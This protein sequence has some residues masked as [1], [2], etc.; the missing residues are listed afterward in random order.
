MRKRTCHRQATLIF[1]TRRPAL[2]R[3]SPARVLTD[4]LFITQITGQVCSLLLDVWIYPKATREGDWIE[5]QRP[6]LRARE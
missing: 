2:G 5:T 1:A 3:R 6:D 4:Y